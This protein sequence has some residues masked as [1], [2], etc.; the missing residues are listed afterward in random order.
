[1]FYE[2]QIN[3]TGKDRVANVI[4]FVG[5]NGRTVCCVSLKSQKGRMELRYGMKPVDMR[6][7]K[8]NK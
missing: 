2:H 3:N 8:L 7:N 4:L 6:G 1:M 5:A